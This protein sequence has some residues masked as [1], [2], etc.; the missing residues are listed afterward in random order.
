MKINT[1]N[2][3]IRE[4]IDILNVSQTEF[5][6]KTKINKS[7]LSNYLNGSRVPRQDQLQKIADAYDVSPAWLMGYDVPREMPV[8]LES[9]WRFGDIEI[10]SLN[11]YTVPANTVALYAALISEARHCTEEQID[12]AIKMLSLFHKDND[13][14]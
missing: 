12:L 8:I 1:S 13:R 4:L 14:R 2:E 6:E 3:R 11:G 7:A 5:C 9:S 10:K